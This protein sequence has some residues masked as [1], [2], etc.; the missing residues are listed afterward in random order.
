MKWTTEN[1]PKPKA[2]EK[3]SSDDASG[4]AFLLCTSGQAFLESPRSIRVCQ[5]WLEN[6]KIHIRKNG[7]A[8]CIGFMEVYRKMMKFAWDYDYSQEEEEDDVCSSE[9]CGDV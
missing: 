8:L 3:S 6:A 4:E 1:K 9:P 2:A 7:A 5:T